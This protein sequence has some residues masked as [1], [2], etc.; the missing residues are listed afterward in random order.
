[1]KILPRWTRLQS[2]SLSWSINVAVIFHGKLK[3][4]WCLQLHYSVTGF[5]ILLFL[6]LANF[7]DFLLIGWIWIRNQS[8]N[9]WHFISICNVITVSCPMV[10]QSNVTHLQTAEF[11]LVSNSAFSIVF[12]HSILV[13]YIPPR[14]EL[15]VINKLQYHASPTLGTLSPF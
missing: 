4:W 8:L 5:L 13:C 15:W 10:I 3:N 7:G 14:G 12:V 6:I 2:E 1:M 11:V 9:R